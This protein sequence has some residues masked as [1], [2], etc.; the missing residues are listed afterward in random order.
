MVLL[1]VCLLLFQLWQSALAHAREFDMPYDAALCHC[2]LSLCGSVAVPWYTKWFCGINACASKVPVYARVDQP[3]YAVDQT[4]F[5]ALPPAG[6]SGAEVANGFPPCSKPWRL[7]HQR[8]GRRLLQELSC[9]FSVRL[10]LRD[11][12]DEFKEAEERMTMT[13]AAKP[14]T[15][16]RDLPHRSF[17]KTTGTST[18]NGPPTRSVTF[19][20]M[21]KPHDSRADAD[22]GW[23]DTKT[24]TLLSSRGDSSAGQDIGAPPWLA[25]ATSAPSR[26]ELPL[27]AV[28]SSDPPRTNPPMDDDAENAPKTTPLSIDDTTPQLLSAEHRDDESVADTVTT[29]DATGPSLSERATTTGVEA[30]T[31]DDDISAFHLARRRVAARDHVEQP[32]RAPEHD[33]EQVTRRV[34]PSPRPQPQPAPLSSIFRRTLIPPTALKPRV[35][36]VVGAAMG[37][38]EVPPTPTDIAYVNVNHNAALAVVRETFSTE[39]YHSSTTLAATAEVTSDG[40]ASSASDVA[41]ERKNSATRIESRGD[42]DDHEVARTLASSE[43]GEPTTAQLKALT[44][45]STAAAP[46]RARV[47]KSS[48]RPS[49][50]TLE[51][52]TVLR[53]LRR[54]ASHAQ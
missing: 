22:G 45:T 52:D 9:D 3:V 25:R 37:D 53:A 21:D 50:L 13:C 4:D 42:I 28:F 44:I 54:T 23:S 2:F 5:S 12:S 49:R 29:A 39:S 20:E 14:W 51:P 38:R 24:M 35:P 16:G 34:V 1:F 47:I 41:E 27:I 40:I 7:A 33:G 32:P 19:Y 48:F 26:H 36:G 8:L 6:D 43:S 17:E 15:M 46:R 10:D 11:R 18:S 31:A 30:E